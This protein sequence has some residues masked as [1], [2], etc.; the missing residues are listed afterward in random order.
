[1]SV[2][3]GERAALEILEYMDIEQAYMGQALSEVLSR[4]NLTGP[5]RAAAVAFA[6]L[7]AENRQ[8]VDFALSQFAKLNKAGRTVRNILRLGAARILFGQ[9][10]EAQAV[11]ASVELCKA[12]G[13]GAQGRFVNAV[14]RNLVR[15]K[16]QIP[17]PEEQSDP[18]GFYS[19][20]YSWPEFVVKQVFSLLEKEQ[21]RAFLQYRAPQPTT[22]RI[23][24]ARTSREEVESLFKAMGVAAQRMWADP[25]AYALEGAEDV[26]SMDAYQ[27]GKFS[28]QGLASMVAAN[29]VALEKGI[30]LDVCAAPGGKSCNIAERCPQARV[31]AF[32]LYPHRVALI[33][34]QSKRLGLSNLIAAQHDAT[35]PLTEFKNRADCVLVDAPCSGLGTACHRPDVKWNK[36]QED[37]AAL[38]NLQ[39][40]IL[41][42]A[43]R[44]VKPGGKLIYCTCTVTQT[45]NEDVAAW[46]ME[47]N[48]DFRLAPLILP[49]NMPGRPDA[50]EGMLRFWPQ[51]HQTD[52]FFICTMER[53]Y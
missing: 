28:L 45:E 7:T 31:Y 18:I 2:R 48:P 29:Q 23:N 16:E 47:N 4:K 33:S 37:M 44:A 11:H 13:K 15:Q 39:K 20:R 36:T 46:F 8:A 10:T 24:P 1:M 6:K 3:A 30:I 9:N 41:Q 14:L 52:G 43:S 26:P 50:K 49:E 27:Q 19:V 32:D 53:I 5:D 21:A 25:R 22:V 17:W 40:E 42:N 35:Q 38:A 34:A 12:F 51:I